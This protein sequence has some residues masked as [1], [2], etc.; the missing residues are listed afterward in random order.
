MNNFLK[1]LK[2]GFIL[3]WRCGDWPGDSR[4]LYY[5]LIPDGLKDFLANCYLTIIALGA[6]VLYPVIQYVVNPF[7]LA[8]KDTD[9]ELDNKLERLQ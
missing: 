2:I 8:F 5:D 7:V 6:I 4:S 9:E 1:R 3:S